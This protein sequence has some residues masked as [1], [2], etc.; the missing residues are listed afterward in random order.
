MGHP[1]LMGRTTFESI[2]HPLPG[3]LTTVLSRQAGFA[4]LGVTMASNLPTALREADRQAN[5]LGATAIMVVGGGAVYSATIGIAQTL[6]I[7]E[8]DSCPAGDTLFPD[9]NEGIWQK[10][11]EEEAVPQQGDTCRYRFVRWDRKAPF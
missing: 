8:V 10:T 4:P 9:I 3:R 6:L 2:G 5:E 11:S 7:T 1:L